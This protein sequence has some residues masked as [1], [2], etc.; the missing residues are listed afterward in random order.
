[1]RYRLVRNYEENT[2]V[3]RKGLRQHATYSGGWW[4]NSDSYIMRDF[5]TDIGKPHAKWKKSRH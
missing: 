1:M 5:L 4:F 2:I 3:I